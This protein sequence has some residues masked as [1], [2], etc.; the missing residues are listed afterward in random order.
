[1]TGEVAGSTAGAFPT[2]RALGP[3]TSYRVGSADPPV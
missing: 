1:M 2:R 3:G